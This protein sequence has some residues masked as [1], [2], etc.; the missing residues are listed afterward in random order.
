MSADFITEELIAD[1]RDAYERREESLGLDPD[2]EPVMRELERRVLLSV[3]DRRWREHLYEMDYL[4]EGIGLR[5]YGQRDPLVEYQREAYDM[6]TVMMEGIKEESVGFL[7]FAEV[8]VE[9]ESEAAGDAE[10]TQVV[11]V[12]SD[13][14]I[15]SVE[16]PQLAPGSA[17]HAAPPPG[18]ADEADDRAKVAGVLGKAFGQPNR[19]ANL[20]YSAPTVDGEG[21]V[22]RSASQGRRR[23]GCELRQRLAERAL[24]LWVGPQVQAL[25]RRSAGR[26]LS[27]SRLRRGRDRVGVAEQVD[28]DRLTLTA[29]FCPVPK[30]RSA[31]LGCLLFC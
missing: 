10:D 19:P 31:L 8:N 15:A 21:G 24:P 12:D 3:L 7:F 2:G 11:E 25:P 5:G 30:I 27:L 16:A 26:R 18:P 17:P 6:F 22:E 1:A 9:V 29:V 14:G 13:E 23:H 20:Q 28:P 4:Q